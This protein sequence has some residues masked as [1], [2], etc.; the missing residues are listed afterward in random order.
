MF[1]DGTRSTS[2]DLSDVLA[3]AP[4]LLLALLIF[5]FL[6]FITD[7]DIL[8]LAFEEGNGWLF[9]KA[10]GTTGEIC[11]GEGDPDGNSL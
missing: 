5:A 1:A 4:A 6:V 2:L 11:E 10:R 3:M 8:G 9:R 7:G